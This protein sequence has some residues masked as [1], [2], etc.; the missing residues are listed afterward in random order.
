MIGAWERERKSP[1]VGLVILVS[2]EANRFTGAAQLAGL[3]D[4]IGPPFWTLP[5]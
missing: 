2:E 3:D 4:P 1:D 5:A